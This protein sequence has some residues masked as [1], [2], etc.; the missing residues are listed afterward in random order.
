M[1]RTCVDVPPQPTPEHGLNDLVLE[2]CTLI[3]ELREQ[4]RRMREV[5]EFIQ[6]GLL[7]GSI[8]AKPVIFHVPGAKSMEHVS[9][10][11]VIRN[12]VNP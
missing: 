12:A 9:L 3:E 5:L 11:H 7:A 1:S 4:N 2:A 6:A 10:T 8:T